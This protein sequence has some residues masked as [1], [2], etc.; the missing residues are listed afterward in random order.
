MYQP[1]QECDRT[2]VQVHE[3]MEVDRWNTTKLRDLISQD[4]VEHI[5][6]NIPPP[7]EMHI[8]DKPYWKLEAKGKFTV[9]SAYQLVRQR[10][11]TCNLHKKM[12]I[13]GLHVVRRWGFQFPSKCFCCQE[14]KQETFSH[15][16][17]QSPATQFKWRQ[18]SG[19][20]GLNIQ[21]L[22][23]INLWWEA[24]ANQYMREVFTAIPAIILWELWKR[25]NAIKHGGKISHE[26]LMYQ[27]MHTIVLMLKVR[28]SN[29]KYTPY[30]WKELVQAL[31]GYT[32]KIRVEQ[33][34]WTI[35]ET[36]SLKCNTHGASRGNPG[37]SA[38]GFSVRNDLG[39]VIK[40]QAAEIEDSCTTNTQA[41]AMAILQALRS[42]KN[43]EYIHV[44][45][46]TDS[47]LMVKVIKKNWEVPWQI[48]NIVDE[49]WE[50]MRDRDIGDSY[51]KGRKQT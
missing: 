36:R 15:V 45:I 35:P 3:V 21:R 47:P 43:M 27:V 30:D 42:I 22:Q 6:I 17:L 7:K 24:P 26:K 4:K 48:V 29:F 38:W 2:V 10:K 51:I 9:R 12:W 19:P 11:E 18:F 28:R 32:P 34:L 31:Q 37:R 46:E 40:A 49:I 20:L 14:H 39:D 16:F 8:K 33:V 41:K 25:R 23:V 13:R 50:I 44:T 1:N 5:L